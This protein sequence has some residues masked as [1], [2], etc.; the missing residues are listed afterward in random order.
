MQG[1]NVDPEIEGEFTTE[2]GFMSNDFFEKM[3]NGTVKITIDGKQVTGFLVKFPGNKGTPIYSIMTNMKSINESHVKQKKDIEITLN[4][5]QPFK[6]KL[7]DSQRKISQYHIAFEDA[8]VIQVNEAYA[9]EIMQF[10]C[11]YNFTPNLNASSY[12]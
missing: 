12:F 8:T 9:N 1:L 10:Y 7:D 6:I 3:K 11:L 5:A 2:A 4:K